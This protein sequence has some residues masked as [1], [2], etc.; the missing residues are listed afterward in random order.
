MKSKNSL[1][2]VVCV[3]SVAFASGQAIGDGGRDGVR[4]QYEA[5]TDTPTYT[6]VAV[7]DGKAETGAE[8]K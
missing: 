2:T 1:L 4:G 5:V 7:L 6:I 3:L 8:L